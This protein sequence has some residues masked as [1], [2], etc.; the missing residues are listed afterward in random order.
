MSDASPSPSPSPAPSPS[1]PTPRSSSSSPFTA[2][3]ASPLWQQQRAYFEAQGPS[4]WAS[5]A[6]PHYVTSNPYLARAFAEVVVGFAADRARV[7]G[8]GARQLTIVE[9]GAGAG[10]LGY[11]LVRALRGALDAAAAGWAPVYVLT[12]LA[13]S[14]V[15]WWRAHPWLQPLFAAGLLDIARFD[16]TRDHELVLQVS[17]KLRGSVRVPAAAD[18]ATIEAAALAHPD[19]IR[20]MDGKPARKIVIVKGRLVNIVV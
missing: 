11:H 10:R 20:F 18:Q 7:H 16:A 5:G 15:A 17:G 3:S 13:A 14:T 8:P 4:A 9:L 1:T 2:L 6:V 19:A 12:D